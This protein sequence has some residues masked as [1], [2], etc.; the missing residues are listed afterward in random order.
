MNL[1]TGKSLMAPLNNTPPVIQ[2]I[3]VSSEDAST[4]CLRCLRWACSSVEYDWL[5]PQGHH[6]YRFATDQEKEGQWS[7]FG[8]TLDPALGIRAGTPGIGKP[9]LACQGSSICEIKNRWLDLQYT[10]ANQD[11]LIPQTS[12]C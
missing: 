10:L 11:V 4:L 1:L 7:F 12:A 2:H 6:T 8:E 3:A 9:P 5:F